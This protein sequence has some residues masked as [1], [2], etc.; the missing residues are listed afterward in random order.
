MFDLRWILAM[1]F[2]LYGTV[3]TVLG[4]AF[5]TDLDLARAGG[6]NVNLWVGI[7]MLIGAALF[8]TWAGLRPLRLPERSG[9]EQAEQGPTEQGPTP[10]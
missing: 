3:L 8:G 5:T 2:T 4:A 6:V 7:G 9:T 1:L 10:S